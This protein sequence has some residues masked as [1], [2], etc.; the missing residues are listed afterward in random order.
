MTRES[1]FGTL[2]D[3]ALLKDRS[4]L[5]HLHYDL[6][7]SYIF[8]GNKKLLDGTSFIMLSLIAKIERRKISSI[9]NNRIVM[10]F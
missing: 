5:F 6:V 2:L 8:R 7:N 1:D 3:P 10:K 9:S 4:K